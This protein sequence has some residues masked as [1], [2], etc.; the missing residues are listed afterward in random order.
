MPILTR[1]GNFLLLTD[2]TQD[3]RLSFSEATLNLIFLSTKVILLRSNYP[4]LLW[5]S[6]T[7]VENTKM[8]YLASEKLNLNT[9]RNIS[10]SQIIFQ[11][12]F[13]EVSIKK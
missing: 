2:V 12:I 5:R 13:P 6:I 11:S 3:L 8:M 10:Y 1:N 4:T 7:F 9:L